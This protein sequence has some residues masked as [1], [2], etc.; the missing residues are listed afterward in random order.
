M[1]IIDTL[2]YDMEPG[3]NL[4]RLRLFSCSADS[5]MHP[6]LLLKRENPRHF[7]ALSCVPYSFQKGE[8][9]ALTSSLLSSDLHSALY[10]RSAAVSGQNITLHPFVHFADK[11]SLLS[12][13]GE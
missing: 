8:W 6:S 13:N 3:F 5:R 7:E 2:Y 9:R 4:A 12:H 10:V 11:Q 1:I